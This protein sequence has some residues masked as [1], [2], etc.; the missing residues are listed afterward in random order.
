MTPRVPSQQSRAA[1]HAAGEKHD[2][3]SAAPAEP[4]LSPEPPACGVTWPDT[5]PDLSSDLIPSLAT[6]P[7]RPAHAPATISFE[8][9]PE[10]YRRLPEMTAR[11]ERA[12]ERVR[13]S[14][15]PAGSRSKSEGGPTRMSE[16]D[17]AGG[18]DVTRMSEG[19]AAAGGEESRLAKVT[20]A[21]PERPAARG[22]A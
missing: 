16:G 17:A 1:T 3:I 13:A 6:L 11:L 18:E 15:A 14:S 4:P 8:D 19:D 12:L 22:G 9:L 21:P 10:S 20:R 5:F 7:D 2:K